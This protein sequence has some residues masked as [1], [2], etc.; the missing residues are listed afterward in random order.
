MSGD[1]TF[2]KIAAAVLATALGFMLIK[3]VS[4]SAMH[5]EIPEELA[6]GRD[7]VKD[8]GDVDV[9]P[10]DLPFPQ[11]TWVA[12][13]DAVKGAKVFKKCTSC[14]NA[15]NGGKDGTGPNLWN[16][17]GTSAAGKAD[18]AYSGAMT[19]AGISWDY[20]T[21]DAY[22]TKPTKFVPGTKMNFVGLKKEA[23][24][25]AVIEY[26]RVASP[27]P[28][29]QPAAAVVAMDETVDTIADNAEKGAEMIIDGVKDELGVIPETMEGATEEI[30][31]TAKD[32][33]EKVEDVVEDIVEGD[34]P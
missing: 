8:T 13:M 6:Y 29:A 30:E 33:I 11:E 7:L 27:S 2:N 19:N 34:A 26:L 10:V 4:H 1:L 23:D 22:L 16:I 20:E 31:D 14:H 17:V 9:V 21:L 18:F 5:V 12:S 3:E 24:R 15:D 32:L 25:A 28:I